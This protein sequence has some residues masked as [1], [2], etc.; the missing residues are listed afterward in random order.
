MTLLG[1]QFSTVDE[2]SWALH[3]KGTRWLV[4][5]WGTFVQQAK[6]SVWFHANDEYFQGW[7]ISGTKIHF[8]RRRFLLPLLLRG[9]FGTF[10]GLYNCRQQKRLQ[11]EMQSTIKEQKRLVEITHLNSQNISVLQTQIADL[12]WMT[13]ALTIS[14]PVAIIMKAQL[15]EWEICDEIDRI[16]DAVQTAQLRCLSPCYFLVHNSANFTP[17]WPSEPT[18]Y[19]PTFYLRILPICSKLKFCTSM[20]GRKPMTSPSFFM[21]LWLRNVPY[22][23][24]SVFYCFHC[25]FPTH[26]FWFPDRIK[27]FLLSPQT[28]HSCPSTWLKL[29]WK[30]VTRSAMYTS[31]NDLAF[32]ELVMKVPV[33]DP[34]TLNSLKTLW[35]IVRWTLFLYPNKSCSSPQL[36]F[37]LFY[38]HLHR[39]NQLPQPHCFRT[40]PENWYEQTP[41]FPY[42]PTPA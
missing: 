3:E 30:A 8:C 4:K 34:S 13:A 31:A 23:A 16:V 42:L 21:S 2:R 11:T 25:R 28:N 19:R 37:D 24:S 9:V 36:V 39:T 33:L 32:H 22:F 10:M 6:T 40:P 20:M 29:I 1:R 41:G 12:K 5:T 18:P 7:S 26:T 15:M 35:P 38:S 14:S 27:T 17:S